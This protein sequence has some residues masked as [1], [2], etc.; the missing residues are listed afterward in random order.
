MI[1]RSPFLNEIE[2]HDIFNQGHLNIWDELGAKV[3]WENS[4]GSSSAVSL[5]LFLV[6]KVVQF[7]GYDDLDENALIEEIKEGALGT[8][9]ANLAI[10]LVRRRAQE[11]IDAIQ[12]K[13]RSF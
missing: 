5:Y 8:F 6:D 7:Y 4:G 9:N 3:K 1:P 13:G 12:G 2:A 10:D 11:T